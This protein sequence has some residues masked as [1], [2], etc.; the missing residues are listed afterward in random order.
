LL[1]ASGFL[2]ARPSSQPLLEFQAVSVDFQLELDLPL[3]SGSSFII[4]I[5]SLGIYQQV[6]DLGVLGFQ[7]FQPRSLRHLHTPIL[8]FQLVD[9][10]LGVDIQDALSLSEGIDL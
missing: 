4:R 2:A 5:C 7:G 8:G 10:H 9:L 6:L 1:P 3:R